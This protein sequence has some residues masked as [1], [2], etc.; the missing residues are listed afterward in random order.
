MSLPK[1]LVFYDQDV[2][3]RHFLE[4][5]V[6]EELERAYQV[7][8]VFH[9]DSTSQKK[10]IHADID[11]LKVERKLF[12]DVPRKRGGLW[13]IL[14]VASTQRHMRNLPNYKPLMRV[15]GLTHSRKLM[16]LLSVLA[17][18]GIFELFQWLFLRKM[19]LCAT[20]LNLIE[21]EKP[22]ILIHPSIM[23][24]YLLDD[25]ILV[26]QKTDVPLLCLM[27]SWDNPSQKHAGAGTPTKLVVW[28]QQ[29]RQ[30]AITYF[31][32]HPEDVVV[33]GAAQLDI[34]RRPV[35]FTDDESRAEFGVPSGIPIVLYA[36][37]SK[38][39]LESRHLQMLDEAIERG[40]IPRSHILYRPHPWRCR[41]LEGE[42]DIRQMGLKNVSIDPHMAA[43]YDRITRENVP[44]FQLADYGVIARQ[45]HMVSA[46]ISPLSTIMVEAALNGKPVLFLSTDE[47]YFGLPQITMA[48][49]RELVHFAEFFGASGVHECYSSA[50]LPGKVCQ[51]LQDAGDPEIKKSLKRH[52]EFFV[53]LGEE[54]YGRRVLDLANELIAAKALRVKDGR[55]AA[56]R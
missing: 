19:G 43:Y 25:L 47:D 36:G 16:A 30:H 34:Y 53:H 31:G 8:H 5:G 17:L 24:G 18:P 51:L 20:L 11:Q 42:I 56:S 22:D 12:V 48:M 52:G 37:C 21:T 50:D 29:T 27:N 39:V 6:F 2:T 41:L 44:G 9:I 32:M 49:M 38:G 13:D 46:V 15:L 14:M 23:M 7:S 3:V 55:F 26:S 28:G 54:S 35:E 1:A 40:A 10:N 45:L 33:G 4:S